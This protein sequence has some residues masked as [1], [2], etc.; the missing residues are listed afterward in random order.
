MKDYE[1]YQ[2]FELSYKTYVIIF[3]VIV[4]LILSFVIYYSSEKDKFIKIAKAFAYGVFFSFISIYFITII[5]DQ[6]GFYINRISSNKSYQKDFKITYRDIENG[7]KIVRLKSIFVDFRILT[8]NKFSDEDL[9]IIQKKDTITIE[10]HVGILN[11]P[12][13]KFGKI[14]IL[15]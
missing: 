10:Y 4:F 14:D 5:K 7:D 6:T 13:L 12:F 11:K 2:S 9:L 15:D 1:D 8:R 3:L